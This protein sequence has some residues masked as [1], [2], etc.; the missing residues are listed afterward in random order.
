MVGAET[1]AHCSKSILALQLYTR[2]T[3]PLS[4]LAITSFLEVYEV[5]TQTGK[6]P[7][8]AV[9]GTH[10]SGY[11]GIYCSISG[12]LITTFNKEL[13]LSLLINQHA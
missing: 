4:Q 9:N 12:I 8:T 3:S 11:T 6:H 13:I 2:F 7:D 1:L 10:C 5:T